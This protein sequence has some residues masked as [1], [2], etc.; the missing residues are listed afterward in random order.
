MMRFLPA[1]ALLSLSACSLP[2][3]KT[4]PPPLGRGEVRSAQAANAALAVGKSTKTD[5]RAALGEP[6]AI[7]FESGYEVWVYREKPPEKAAAPRTELVLLFE[8]S[9]VLA[10]RRLR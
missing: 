6:V 3:T 7:D 4:D 5:V 2:S 10:K 9:G 8:P 1:L